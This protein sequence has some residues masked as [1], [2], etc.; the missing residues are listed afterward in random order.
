MRL[1]RL[2]IPKYDIMKDEFIKFLKSKRIFS[3]FERNLKSDRDITFDEYS[4]SKSEEG[5]I[6]LLISAFYWD[7]TPENYDFWDEIDEDWRKIVNNT[8]K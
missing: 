2:Y 3:K 6:D 5:G 4:D 1:V 8:K 7:Q